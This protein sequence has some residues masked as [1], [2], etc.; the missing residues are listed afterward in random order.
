MKPPLPPPSGQDPS[1]RGVERLAALKQ[2]R[3]ET[4]RA[5][6]PALLHAI[7]LLVKLEECAL[8]PAPL[9]PGSGVALALAPTRSL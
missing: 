5:D 7:A 6:R 2:L 9:Q 8:Q 3:D 4:A 1:M